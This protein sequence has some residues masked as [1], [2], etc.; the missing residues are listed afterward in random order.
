MGLLVAAG[1]IIENALKGLLQDAHTV[2]PV[3]AHTELFAL[4]AV[5]DHIH[6]LFREA[7]YRLRQGKTVFLG[8]RLEIHTE[9]GIGT[10]AAP[11]G[12]LDRAVKNR[13]ILIG[14]HKILIRNQAEAQAGTIRAG[15]GRIIKGE[16]PGLQLRKADAAILA[17]IVLRKTHLLSRVRKTDYNQAAGM[18]AGGFNRVGNTAALTLPDHQ[19]VYHQFNGMLLIL[20]AGDLLGKIIQNAIHTD[21]GKA[22][23]PGILKHLL[24]LAFFAA[25]NGRKHQKA[26]SL[27]Q[28]KHPVHDLIHGLPADLLTALGTVGNTYPR[29]QKTQVVI[30]LRHRT[31]GGTGVLGGGF[32][33]DGNGRRKTVDGIHIGL[34]HLSQKLPGIGAEALHIPALTFRVNGIERQAG[35]TGTGQTGKDH[36]LVPWN[37][38]IDVLQV[39]FS[40]SP[41][42][43]RIVHS[44]HPFANSS[45]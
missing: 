35:F 7:F 32:L 22:G 21:T 39:V 11:A 31:N 28:V 29:P 2:S 3:V 38:K 10:G 24:M 8:K 42:M 18:G 14:D 45:V 20:F 6:R 19:P 30:D 26:G 23:F 27:P 17:G 44:P 4:G 13:L 16:H 12:D 34:V 9:N 1:N 25:D 43:D 5:Q 36:K 15:T 41:D 40:G 37:G 33:I